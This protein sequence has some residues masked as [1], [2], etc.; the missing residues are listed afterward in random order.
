MRLGHTA[1]IVDEEYL[2]TGNALRLNKSVVKPFLR[3]ISLDFKKQLKSIE[4][5]SQLDNISIL[6]TAH[7][8]F[9]TN[10]EKAIENWKN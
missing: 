8:G 3:I 5:L 6:F 9:T 10:F 1:Y 2:F 7:N 4:M